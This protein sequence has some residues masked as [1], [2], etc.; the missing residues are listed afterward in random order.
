[1]NI[2][3][4]SPVSLDFM[5]VN[6]DDTKEPELTLESAAAA[7]CTYAH[8]RHTCMHMCWLYSK[9]PLRW[10]VNRLKKKNNKKKT[11]SSCPWCDDW[12]L[13]Q[14]SIM[15]TQAGSPWHCS[16]VHP[17][18]S[19]CSVLS[20]EIPQPCSVDCT[21]SADITTNHFHMH[22]VIWLTL[23][24]FITVCGVSTCFC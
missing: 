17:A 21:L 22:Y 10:E 7:R 8:T 18:D 16:S 15:L 1:M 14:I 11:Q 2:S 9:K 3:P 4:L 6:G 5:V 19:N 23:S 12:D 20:V 13:T 24:A